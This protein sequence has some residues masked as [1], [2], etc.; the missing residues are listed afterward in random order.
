MQYKKTP[1]N[2]ELQDPYKKRGFKSIEQSVTTSLNEV[3]TAMLGNR[4]VFPTK[5]KRLN[6]NLLGGLQPGK[7]YVIA[8]RAG[9][10]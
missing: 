2:Q 7:M 10:G 6:K 3:R 4:P 5:W 1:S 9:V 8:G